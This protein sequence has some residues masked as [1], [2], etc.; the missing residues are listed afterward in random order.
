MEDDSGIDFLRL[1]REEFHHCFGGAPLSS[2]IGILLREMVL[3]NFEQR[4]LGIGLRI[5][6]LGFSPYS[7]QDRKPSLLG[8]TTAALIC[9]SK[10]LDGRAKSFP[11]R[12]ARNAAAP[13]NFF[14][15]IAFQPTKDNILRNSITACKRLRYQEISLYILYVCILRLA[16][17]RKTV[18]IVDH[19]FQPL[20]PSDTS[21]VREE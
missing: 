17:Q 18:R 10:A 8:S 20:L 11:R 19:S 3:H 7:L 14:P 1:L 12:S 21:H 16:R 6:H 5:W 2:G 9:L 13:L 15:G 4:L